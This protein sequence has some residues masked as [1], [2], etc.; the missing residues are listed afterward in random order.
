LFVKMARGN[1]RVYVGLTL[2]VALHWSLMRMLFG[3]RGV[4]LA[5]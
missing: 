3:Y 2:A 5:S 1:K 4:A